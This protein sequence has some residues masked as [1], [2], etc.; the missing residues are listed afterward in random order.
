MLRSIP[1]ARALLPRARALVASSSSPPP[2]PPPPPPR[3]HAVAVL[4]APSSVAVVPATH[5]PSP[6]LRSRQLRLSGNNREAYRVARVS[7]LQYSRNQHDLV[8]YLLVLLVSDRFDGPR[9]RLD[10]MISALKHAKCDCSA[11]V[12]NVVL[13][14]CARDAARLGAG[15]HARSQVVLRTAYHV[16]TQL[17]DRFAAVQPRSIALMY[18]ICGD[19]HN[20]QLARHIRARTNDP[21]LANTVAQPVPPLS[22]EHATAAYILCLG[23]CDRAVEAEQLYFS[24]HLTHLRANHRVLGALFQAYVASNR[25]SKAESLIA[26]YGTAFLT[27]QSCNAFV[28]HC[29]QL[30]LHDT[31][32]TFVQRMADSESTAYPPPNARTYNLLLRGLSAGTGVEDRDVAA[33]RALLVVEQMKHQRIHPTT[34]TYNTLIRAFVFRNQIQQALQLYRRMSTPNRITFSHL[35]HA[36]AKTRDIHLAQNL[37]HHLEQLNER[38]N[39][40][41]MKSYL[42][43]IAQVDGVQ[44][45]F[46]HATRL[47]ERFGHVVVFGDVGSAEAVRMALISACGK[48]R[49]VQAAFEALSHNLAGDKGGLLA[50]LYVSTVLMQVC[51]ACGEPGRAL[52]VFESLKQAGLQPNFEVYESL[53]YGL[54]SYVRR[55]AYREWHSA[56]E[57]AQRDDGEEEL[58]TVPDDGVAE[59][60]GVAG[61]ADTQQQAAQLSQCISLIVQLIGEMHASGVARVSRQAAYVYNTVLAA[62]AAAGDLNLA[63]QVFNKMTPT[64]NR[65]IVYVARSN[66]GKGDED[67]CDGLFERE[68]EFPAATVGTYNSMMFAAWKCGVPSFSFEAFDMM[69][70][71]RSAEPNA[72]TLSLLADVAL[73]EANVD[74]EW[75]QKLLQLLDRMPIL[76][77]VV[78]KKRVRLRQKVLALRWS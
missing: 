58:S 4:E 15:S 36:A 74:V 23:K 71:D 22:S 45:A 3:W 20:L 48:V 65:N 60:E 7:G 56:Q 40:S 33:D 35:M 38:P 9:Q 21:V 75:L 43:L 14:A 67:G 69:L 59:V 19:C 10:A 16:W 63:L 51:L 70:S 28:K 76:S 49:D 61:D 24:P 12:Y 73:E 62:A 54:A 34:V 8:E 13:A 41:F 46:E 44:A 47:A 52:E 53:I 25:I 78:C 42:Q 32:I 66:S 1:A 2:P 31:A 77:D 68:V 26:M 50:P 5:A 11:A 17:T 18:R 57:G 55:A 39:Y 64:N 30:R 29:A 6:R 27:V 72:A 37:L